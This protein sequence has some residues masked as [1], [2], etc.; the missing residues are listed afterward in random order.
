[1]T[2]RGGDTDGALPLGPG[3]R[4]LRREGPLL[5][6]DKPDGVR[7]HP[8]ETGRAD[9]L[10]LLAAPY[11]L[12]RECY[13]TA[14]GDVYLL[15][16]L[17]APTSGVILVALDA[18][19]AAQVRALFAA[20]QVRKTYHAL[21]FG[22]MGRAAVH[23]RDRLRVV[24]NKGAVRAETGAGD[25]AMARA[26]GLAE[27]APRGI[28]LSLIEL[29]PLTGRTHQL[30]VQCA[31]RH[32]PIVGDATYGNFP[33]NRRAAQELGIRRLCL[34]AAAVELPVRIGGR[35]LVFTAK[36]DTPTAFKLQV[37]GDK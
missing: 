34:H 33:A 19:L 21:V 29:Q 26:R 13:A 10:A 24:R 3:V 36:S 2:D 32:L 27:G 16:R 18:G 12:K 31:Q 20:H 25:V 37:T 4:L 8:N 6:L 35:E 28:A 22:R 9:A 7:S 14:Q 5:A 11:D 15:N 23:W 30:R 17:D 1:M